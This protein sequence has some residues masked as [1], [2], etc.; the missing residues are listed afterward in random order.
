MNI[1]EEGFW[2][3]LN[4]IHPYIPPLPLRE[5]QEISILGPGPIL[6]KDGAL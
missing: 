3:E 1:S 4:L 5:N 6:R 2:E